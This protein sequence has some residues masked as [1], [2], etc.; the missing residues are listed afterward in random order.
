ML[1]RRLVLY[2]YA[3]DDRSENWRAFVSVSSFIFD[4]G[5]MSTATLSSLVRVI[6]RY[7]SVILSE[8]RGTVK[9]ELGGWMLERCVKWLSLKGS[10]VGGKH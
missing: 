9:Q 3:A 8:D 7:H 4:F 2:K 6:V 1:C 5:Y 10:V